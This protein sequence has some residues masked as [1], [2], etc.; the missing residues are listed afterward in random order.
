RHSEITADRAGMLVVGKEE[1]ARKVLMSWT[2]KS[3]PL[4]ARINQ[5]AWREQ[6]EMADEISRFAEW[7][8]SSTPFLAGRLRL[9]KDF[10]A[11]EGLIGWRALIDHWAPPPP[12]TEAKPETP[13]AA[14]PAD[15][16][17]QGPPAADQNSVRLE[18]V[19]C[20][21]PMR[22]PKSAL[23]TGETVNVRCPNPACRSVL[24]VTPRKPA[25]APAPVPKPDAPASDPNTVRLTCVNCKE[26]M[27]IPKSALEGGEPV[28]V[29]C[30]NAACRAV[31]TVTPKKSAPVSQPLESMTTQD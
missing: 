17:K 9:M 1:V 19:K 24:T 11:S 18:C 20:K 7:T 2:L 28:N 13:K 6:E 22:V 25:A 3:F 31:L 23:E 27:R 12:T 5:D 10:A 29:R 8:L 15:A 26:S 14:P 21:E 30:P 4:Q 16:A